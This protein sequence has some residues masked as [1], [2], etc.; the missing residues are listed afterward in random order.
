MII[1]HFYLNKEIQLTR[2]FFQVKALDQWQ[3]VMALFLTTS[4]VRQRFG[5]YTEG[6]FGDPGDTGSN[7]FHFHAAFKK[8]FGQ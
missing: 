6:A 7:F 3:A 4:Q 8:Q 5:I 2:E 1:T